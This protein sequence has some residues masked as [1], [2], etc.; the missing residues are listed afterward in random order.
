MIP[1]GKVVIKAVNSTMSH[2][3]GKRQ[4]ATVN[5]EI[6]I[7]KVWLVAMADITAAWCGNG[8]CFKL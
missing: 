2:I 5:S 7:G 3:L 8:S 6:P 4:G 1:K